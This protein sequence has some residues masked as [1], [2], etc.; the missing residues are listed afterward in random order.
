MYEP[1]KAVRIPRSPGPLVRRAF[2]AAGLLSIMALASTGPA[3]AQ[4]RVDQLPTLPL[5]GVRDE[6]A[7]GDAFLEVRA[8]RERYY[9]GETISIEIH[10]GI[11]EHFLTEGMIQLFRRRLD[12]PVQL[13]APWFRGSTPIESSLPTESLALEEGSAGAVRAPDRR[14]DG[15]LFQV[16]ELRRRI[17]PTIAG[18]LTIAAPLLR[19]AYATG[20]RED[21]VNGRVPVDRHDAFVFGNELL[22]TILPLPEEG[23][24]ISFTGGLGNFTVVA[25]AEP[26]ELAAGEVLQLTLEVRGEG[27][28]ETIEAPFL[29]LPYFH[30]VATSEERTAQSCRFLYLLTAQRAGARSIPPV[31]VSFFDPA[32]GYR[33]VETER[34]PITVHPPPEEVLCGDPTTAPLR[35]G[36]GRGLGGVAL[37]GALVSTLVGTLILVGWWWGRSR[38]RVGNRSDPFRE[39]LLPAAH[40]FRGTDREATGD[41]LVTFLAACLD[42]P[43]ASVISPDLPDRLEK[44]GMSRECAD[45]A[46]S[47]L[48]VLLAPRFGG[49]ATAGSED[50]ARALVDE[51]VRDEG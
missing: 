16:W 17:T 3:A 45:R 30:P 9:L 4:D 2:L 24:P 48:D 41:S 35:E 5:D 11:E 23:R 10:F 44:A 1:S 49:P 19:F 18:E 50:A 27:D 43:V 20:F 51:I 8:E 12:L 47:L 37:V 31:P 33:T 34:I 14:R 38:V 15:R 25:E 28:L 46:A 39:R 32:L 42:Q 21:F 40:A 13:Q 29:D 6:T 22:L 26:R 36:S 7:K